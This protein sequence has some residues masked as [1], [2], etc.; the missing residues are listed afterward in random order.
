MRER[1]PVYHI[2]VIPGIDKLM[3]SLVN[4]GVIKNIVRF[5]ALADSYNL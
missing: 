2:F 3:H 5:M 4:F 1:M